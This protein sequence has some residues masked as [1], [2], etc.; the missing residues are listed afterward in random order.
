[1]QDRL[2]LRGSVTIAGF[3]LLVWAGSAGL[4][5]ELFGLLLLSAVVARSVWGARHVARVPHLVIGFGRRTARGVYLLMYV[6]VGI[7]LLRAVVTSTP[8][9]TERCLPY[10]GCVV[11]A[12]VLIRW[13]TAALCLP[14]KD[15]GTTGAAAKP[16]DNL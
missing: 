16:A 11:A 12:Q 3:A 8:A 10:L 15:G 6:L 7:E 14:G 4:P 2:H 9:H 13:I 1:M 5:A